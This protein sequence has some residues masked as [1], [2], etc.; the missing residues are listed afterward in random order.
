MTPMFGTLAADAEQAEPQP[1][2]E[3]AENHMQNCIAPRDAE[4]QARAPPNAEQQA[5]APPNAKQQPL[6][7]CMPGLLPATLH[8]FQIHTPVHKTTLNKFLLGCAGC[9]RPRHCL[10]SLTNEGP[11]KLSCCLWTLLH[12]KDQP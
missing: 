5:R 8:C 1:L 12:C 3:Q 7:Q 11:V 6:L 10:V 2:E 9:Q 4:P